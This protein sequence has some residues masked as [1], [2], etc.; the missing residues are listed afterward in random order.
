MSIMDFFRS[1]PQ[2]TPAAPASAPTGVTPPAAQPNQDV[3]AFQGTPGSPQ[4]NN[5]AQ[6]S[7]LDSFAELLQPKQDPNNPAP[8]IPGINLDVAKLE[9]TVKGMDFGI[10]LTPEDVAAMQRGDAAAFQQLLNRTAQAAFLRA[11]VA[12]STVTEKLNQQS[13]DYM[14]KQVPQAVRQQGIL[15]EIATKNPALSHDVAQPF[16]Q[17]IAQQIA[18]NNPNMSAQEVAERTQTFLGLLG[19]GNPAQQAKSPEAKAQ[20]DW[21]KFFD[22]S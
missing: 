5:Q 16:V 9:E 20:Q 17:Q 8:Q 6:P 13:I 1:T 21:S 19:G 7:P 4:N 2:A 12:N 15:S 18:N 22:F 11:A 3:P 14:T 10:Q